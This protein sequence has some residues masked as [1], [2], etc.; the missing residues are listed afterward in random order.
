MFLS[1]WT[2]PWGNLL[3]FSQVLDPPPCH[4]GLFPHLG[5]HLV[6]SLPPSPHPTPGH[7]EAT[8]EGKI[9]VG[10]PQPGV[11]EGSTAEVRR[12]HGPAWGGDGWKTGSG[13]DEERHAQPGPSV[14]PACIEEP[15]EKMALQVEEVLG[16]LAVDCMHG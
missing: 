10:E 4:R 11:T 9:E 7:S 5:L 1:E 2:I 3:V 13:W 8:G 16:I 6:V 14:G 15:V 12:S